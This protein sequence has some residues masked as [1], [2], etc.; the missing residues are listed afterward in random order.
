[1]SAQAPAEAAPRY[2]LITKLGQ[3]G[4][5]RVLLMLSRGHSRA[6]KLVVVKELLP[7]L[8]ND[9]DLRIM[10]LDEGRLA[11]RLNHPNVVQT[12]EVT[13]EGDRPLIV[14][15][16][17]EGQSL[18]AVLN[19]IG[20]PEI[21]LDLHL[22][23]L[24]QVLAGLHYAHELCD[25]DGSSLC[26]VHRDVSP[27]NV[28]VTY[29]GHV[30]LV[31]FGIA[32]A[33]GADNH[34]VTGVFKG[35]INY[36]S[37]EQIE[38]GVLDRRSDIFAVGVM[39]WEALAG[40]R[41]NPAPADG[42]AISR[43][44]KGNDPKL[45]EVAPD[46]PAELVRIC[47]K[48]MAMDPEDRFATADELRVA[49]SGY[50]ET[51][52]RIGVHEVAALMREAFAAERADVRQ[53]IDARMKEI[54]TALSATPDVPSSEPTEGASVG[55]RGRMSLAS[56]HDGDPSTR[57]EPSRPERARSRALIGVALL[58]GVAVAGVALALARRPAPGADAT[59]ASAQ[60]ASGVATG[61][62]SVDVAIA[63]EPPAARVFLDDV[64]MSTNPFR[65]A[66]PRG[67]ATH[68]VRATAPGF[69]T[70]ERVVVFDRDL[71]LRLRLVPAATAS[72][73][74][75]ASTAEARRAPPPPARPSYGAPS[76]PTDVTPPAQP[77]P[78]P[79]AP[80]PATP[81]VGDSLPT[82]P[83]KRARPIDDTY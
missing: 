53:I 14:M 19:R 62:A 61:A 64:A 81:K 80:A 9:P 41:I 17:L 2:Q 75:A 72:P 66:L 56:D 83:S 23:V 29:D 22:F 51:S 68:H 1:M 15:E 74:G 77:T 24:T 79:A 13:S 3:G 63:A 55:T 82:R 65:G 38:R 30:K 7:T 76:A 69:V 47:E 5:A 33:A 27:Q 4:M 67:P 43:R 25:F 20:R 34:T 40:R 59:A 57:Q 58:A 8:A 50:L 54:E 31:D 32:K 10:F 26:V 73:T 28:F 45:A 16:Y 49:L 42:N 18:S 71:E 44:L 37:P 46:A 35:K 70:E 36:A 21:S 6:H 60:T 39:L 11:V 52:K 12:Y 48:A 78:P